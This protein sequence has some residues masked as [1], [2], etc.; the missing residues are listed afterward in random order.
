MALCAPRY[1]GLI[2]SLK[3]VPT[4]GGLSTARHALHTGGRRR[5]PL[6]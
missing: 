3:S 2:V 1:E 5:I 6:V 4:M